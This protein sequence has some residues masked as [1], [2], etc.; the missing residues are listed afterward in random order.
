AW[1][2]DWR[3]VGEVFAALRIELWLAAVAVYLGTQ[4]ASAARWR[5]LA[6]PLGLR[7]S[8]REFAGFYC[9]GMYFNLILPTSVGGDVVRAWYL[10]RRTGRRLT[11]FLSVFIDRLSGL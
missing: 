3:Q 2:V 5:L 7:H 10:D 6:R 4:L 9:I 11:A 8:L 1:R